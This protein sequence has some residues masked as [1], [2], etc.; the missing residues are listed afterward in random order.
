MA[1]LFSI[2]NVSINNI[3]IKHVNVSQMK[4]LWENLTS[5]SH[6]LHSLS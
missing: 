2:I 3:D 5:I 6:R 4:L 1:P